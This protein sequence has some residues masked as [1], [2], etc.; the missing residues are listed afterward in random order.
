MGTNSLLNLNPLLTDRV[1]LSIM[2]ALVGRTEPIDFNSLLE[3][4]EVSKGNLST[5]IRRLE[6]AKLVEVE[7]SFVGR[8]PLTTYRCTKRGREEMQAYLK[9]LELAFNGKGKER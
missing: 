4:L 6:E 3:A 9:Q 1:R 8:K 7:K 2:A 5:H